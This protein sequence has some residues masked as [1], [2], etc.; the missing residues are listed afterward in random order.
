MST[1]MAFVHS[2]TWGRMYT[3]NASDTQR[4]KIMILAGEWLARKRA[5]AAPDRI[6]L[7]P[8]SAG[9]K[10]NSFLPP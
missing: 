7:L 9:R 4:P 3:K 2:R 10:P 6:D 8:M 1:D 5:M